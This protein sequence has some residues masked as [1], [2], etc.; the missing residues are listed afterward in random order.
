MAVAHTA[1]DAADEATRPPEIQ[2]AVGSGTGTGVGVTVGL[3]TRGLCTV[4]GAPGVCAPG[5]GAPGV[6]A[7]TPMRLSSSLVG[8]ERPRSN[9]FISAGPFTEAGPFTSGI[10]G[11]STHK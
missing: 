3:C 2:C 11:K 9:P 6:C 10:A 1:A 4:G 8:H 5:V 7:R